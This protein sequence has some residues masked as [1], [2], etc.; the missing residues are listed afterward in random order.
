MAVV[1]LARL[2]NTDALQVHSPEELLD[3]LHKHKDKLVVLMCKAISCRPCKVSANA[4]SSSLES[5]EQQLP[6]NR[7][8]FSSQMFGRKYERIAA[9]HLAEGTVFLEILGDET[10]E[11]RVSARGMHARVTLPKCDHGCLVLTRLAQS[12]SCCCAFAG[13]HDEHADK[14]NSHVLLLS[15]HA[16]GKNSDRCK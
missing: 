16:E 7:R 15:K 9:E 13:A 14:G 4:A 5:L 2:S 8:L 10:S 6:Y 12:S 1:H 3:Q 11:T